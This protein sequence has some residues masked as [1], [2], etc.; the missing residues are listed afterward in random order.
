MISHRRDR[1]A[2]SIL[3]VLIAAAIGFVTYSRLI[4]N[5]REQDLVGVVLVDNAD[6]RKQVPIA[7]A[8]VVASAGKQSVTGR[9]DK[10]GMFRLAVSVP[11]GDDPLS[12]TLSHPEY[13]SLSE[14]HID[15]RRLLVLCLQPLSVASHPTG[16]AQTL[17]ISNV[18]L[19]YTVKAQNT[20][21]VGS[22]VRWFEVANV[23][24]VPCAGGPVCSPD[25]RWRAT[26]QTITYDAGANN[27]FVNVRAS[28]VSGPCVF[29]QVEASNISAPGQ[30]LHITVRNWSDPVTF[31]V[32]AEVS[33]SMISDMLRISFPAQ[34]GT[35]M[36][37]TLPPTA[38]GPSIEA[39]LGGTPIVFPLGPSLLLS[40][41]TCNAQT[42]ADKTRLFRCELKPGFAFH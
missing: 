26:E 40:W 10:S 29:S 31:L 13:R 5:P 38:E 8:T 22:I 36:D 42:G 34:F 37:F 19:R 1:L 4:S 25:G 12:L 27:E 17:G 9:T 35:T 30:Q 33:R 20:L 7:D 3:V 6:G 14:T 18:K 39:E 23:A 16:D 15:G 11:R 28:C 24:N 2:A 41:A 21:N 32:E